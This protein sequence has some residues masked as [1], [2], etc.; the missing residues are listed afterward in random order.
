MV[1][2]LTRKPLDAMNEWEYFLDR[3]L[4][5]LTDKW[6]EPKHEPLKVSFRLSAP[7]ALTH[8]WMHFDSL[9]AHLLMR[10]AMGEDYYL[11][12]RKFPFSRLLRNVELPS[13][14][15][16]QTKD[17]F[18]ASV[19]F[20]DTGRQA[21]EVLYK[22]FEDRWV[23]GKRKISRGSGYFRD[24]MIQHIYIPAT[25]V[26]FYVCG[27]GEILERLCHLVIGLGDNS[28]IGW[29]AVRKVEITP[30]QEDWSIVYKGVAMRPI[31]EHHLSYASE[32]MYLAWR[33]P[34]WASE[35]V[36]LCA[37]PGAKVR[38]KWEAKP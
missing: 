25:I 23:G 9:V 28:R 6:Q 24:Y 8:P 38:L 12:P 32:R 37:P 29:G 1:P 35:N 33:P 26:E 14:P 13:H 20:F 10:D 19:S 17:L 4:L 11:L 7:I 21:V 3:F 22:R 30:Q 5:G 34:Y 31:P 15:I 18:H 16:K 27:D 2:I 36:D